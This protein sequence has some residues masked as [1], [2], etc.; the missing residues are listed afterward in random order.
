MKP[1]AC[2]AREIVRGKPVND[3]CR[4][5]QAIAVEPS[6]SP[7]FAIVPSR[8]VGL[9]R[10][11]GAVVDLVVADQRLGEHHPDRPLHARRRAVHRVPAPRRA[12]VVVELVGAVAAD[13]HLERRVHDDVPARARRQLLLVGELGVEDRRRAVAARDR[14][15]A[16]ARLERAPALL[17]DLAAELLEAVDALLERGSARPRRG[18][19]GSRPGACARRAGSRPRRACACCSAR[20]ASA[21]AR[22]ARRSSCTAGRCRPR[23]ASSGRPGRRPACSRRCRARG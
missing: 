19:C 2:S 6:A 14:H 17:D 8:E 16:D 4:N 9:D 20:G 1:R 12:A 21:R 23:S 7:R 13:P 22:R 18:S 10:E 5:A 11:V 15:L 3:G